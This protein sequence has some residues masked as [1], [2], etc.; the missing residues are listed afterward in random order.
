MAPLAVP[1]VVAVVTRGIDYVYKA[2]ITILLAVMLLAFAAPKASAAVLADD[3]ADVMYHSYDGGGVTIDGPSVLVRKKFF[4]NFSVT[5]NYYVDSVTSASIDVLVS[6]SPYTEER[7]QTSVNFEALY[8]STIFSWGL[9]QSDENDYAAE[10][11]MFGVS[12]EVFD[13][14]TTI[15]MGYSLGDDTVSQNG[16]DDFERDVD[17]QSYRLGLSQ[18]ITKNMLVGLSFE[19]ITDEGFLN[20]PYRSVRFIDGNVTGTQ[21]ERYPNTRTSNAGS[22][23][24]RYYLP[25]RAAIHGEYRYFTDTWGIEAHTGQI[26][27]THPTDFGWEFDFHVRLYSQTEADFYS[28][29]FSRA[30]AQNFLARDKE[31]STFTSSSIRLGATYTLF[32][33]GWS[34]MEKGTV[35]IFLDRMQFDYDNFRDLTVHLPDSGQSFEFGEEPLYGFSANVIQFF[36]SVWF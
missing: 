7:T 5:A 10:T 35:N 31:L 20:N 29:L 18:V 3:R 28:D 27:Y 23:R 12:Q 22:I 6:A 36:V 19:A 9:A 4:N 11:F 25:W 30:D 13:G 32:E 16:R 17:R 33:H 24:S 21:A 1:V 14:L 8:G 26:G 34:F 15:S 2:S